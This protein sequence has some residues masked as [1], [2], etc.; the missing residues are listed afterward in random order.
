[1]KLVYDESKRLQ[2]I[3]KHGFDFAALDEDFFADAV[4]VEAKEHRFMAIGEIAGQIVVAVVFAPLGSE[5]FSIIS[6]RRASRK[7][8]NAYAQI[9]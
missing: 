8:R 7:E 9:A 4:V 3:A 1:M 5:A 2:N 6:M